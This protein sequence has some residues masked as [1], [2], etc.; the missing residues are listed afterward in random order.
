MLFGPGPGSYFDLTGFSFQVPNSCF[1]AWARTAALKAKPRSAISTMIGRAGERRFIRHL[2]F[3][4]SRTISITRIRTAHGGRLAD[5]WIPHFTGKV[6]VFV[7]I[8]PAMAP[9]IYR[10]TMVFGMLAIAELGAV[11]PAL[12]QTLVQ[13]DRAAQL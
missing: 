2:S 10:L 8:C 7:V 12:A 1:G 3:I 13:I 6:N 11:R 9:G 5:R 4:R